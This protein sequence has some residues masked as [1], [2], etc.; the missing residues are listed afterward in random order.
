MKYNRLFESILDNISSDDAK[1]NASDRLAD[2]IKSD[3]D[4]TFDSSNLP[5]TTMFTQM[6]AFMCG[7][8]SKVNPVPGLIKQELDRFT[9]DINDIFQ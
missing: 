7:L 5:K 3:N 8:K 4:N 6:L 2:N 9:E 1:N